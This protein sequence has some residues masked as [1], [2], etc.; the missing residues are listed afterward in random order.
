MNIKDYKILFKVTARK[1][2]DSDDIN[3]SIKLRHTGDVLR[4]ITALGNIL[5]LSQ[6]QLLIAQ[7]SGLFHDLGR[8]YQFQHYQTFDDSISTNHAQV[9]IDIINDNNLLAK[10]NAFEQ[11]LI[12]TAILEHNKK[13]M[14]LHLNT[15]EEAL[16]ALLRDADKS[17]NFPFFI[18]FYNEF[19][20]KM[21]S[22]NI[23]RSELVDS[24]LNKVPVSN[25]KGNLVTMEDLYLYHLSWFN[26]LNYLASIQLVLKNE[27]IQKIIANITNKELAQNLLNHFANLPT[28]TTLKTSCNF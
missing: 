8:F 11:K 12:I 4:I 20:K 3:Y 24:V 23:Y 7:V 16:A 22:S 19:G 17:S 9:S 6:Q 1:F 26:D 5:Q 18:K 28:C 25:A 2:I 15:R 13:D 27:Y 10:F 21:P 14:S